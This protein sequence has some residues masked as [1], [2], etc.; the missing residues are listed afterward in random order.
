MTARRRRGEDGFSSVEVVIVTPI[1]VLVFLV[2]V[3]FGHAVT[4]RSDLTNAV[5]A[6]ARAGSLQRSYTAAI[7]AAQHV[8]DADLGGECDGGPHPTWP[9]PGSFTAGGNFVIHV[10][11]AS[12]LLGLPALPPDVTLRAVGVSPI[13]AFRGLT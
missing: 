8:L 10:D 5:N 11:C 7:A 4:V 9:A 6:A 2:M 1:L 3:A 13:D 12:P